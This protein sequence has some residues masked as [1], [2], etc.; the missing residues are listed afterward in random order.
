MARALASGVSRCTLIVSERQLRFGLRKL[1]RACASCPLAWS[2]AAW[3]GRWVDFE[4]NVVFVDERTFAVVLLYEI[5]G[6][7]RLD[8]AH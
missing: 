2:R 4:E 8:V 3:N 5:A 1:A 7:L 6:D